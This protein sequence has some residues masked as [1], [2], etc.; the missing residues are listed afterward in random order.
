MKTLMIGSKGPGVQ[1]LQ[2]ALNRWGGASLVT[3]GVFGPVTKAALLRFQRAEGITPDGIAGAQTHRA[4][5][6][7]YTGAVRH[8]IRRGDTLWALSRRYGGSIDA[9]R[10]ANPGLDPDALRVGSEIT[11]PLDF[12]V[13]PTDIAYSSSLIT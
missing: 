2:L 9:I 6:P 11:V 8:V 12:P 5:L 4:L 3:D 7:W 13:V 1:L 10:T